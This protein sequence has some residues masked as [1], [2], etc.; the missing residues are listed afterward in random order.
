MILTFVAQRKVCN[1]YFVL[2]SI[3]RIKGNLRYGVTYRAVNS[4]GCLSYK[5]VLKSEFCCNFEADE[6]FVTKKLIPGFG[7][8]LLLFCAH[9]VIPEVYYS[10]YFVMDKMLSCKVLV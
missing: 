7:A 1:V 5:L 4:Q 10:A 2:W 3:R 9:I 8:E 6:D